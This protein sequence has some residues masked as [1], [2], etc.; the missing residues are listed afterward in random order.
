MGR[1]MSDGPGTG[2]PYTK[3]QPKIA[4]RCPS[5]GA[6]SL[7]VGAGGWLTCDVVGCK[8]PGVSSHLDAERAHSAKLAERVEELERDRDAAMDALAN[9]IGDVHFAD[10]AAAQAENVRLREALTEAV[11]VS[12]PRYLGD[13]QPEWVE[14]ADAALATPSPTAALRE[15]CGKVASKAWDYGFIER[16]A[17]EVAGAPA[18]TQESHAAKRAADVG[19]IVSSILGPEVRT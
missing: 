18:L 10:L 8:E 12:G 7:F 1:T 15:V 9:K 17:L 16:G 19:P 6:Q 4:D 11:R 2:Q 14:R 13:T 3:E 5:C